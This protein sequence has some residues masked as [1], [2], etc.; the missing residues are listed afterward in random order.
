MNALR[1]TDGS[2][3]ENQYPANYM[4]L[5]M[6]AGYHWLRGE[7][8]QYV[9]VPNVVD[10]GG[11]TYSNFFGY[12]EASDGDFGW[13]TGY[14]RWT[15]AI[16]NRMHAPTSTP[17]TLESEEGR[18]AAKAWLYNHAGDND[19][20]AGGLIAIDVAC[21]TNTRRP[22]P[23][24]PANDAA[25]VTGMEYMHWAPTWATTRSPSWD[26]TTA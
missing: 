7:I 4:W 24:T 26:M 20:K 12:Q 25:Q 23:K 15:R 3:A 14:D 5:L 10:Y 8:M 21:G 1:D 22:I 9:G 6:S 2:L 19:Y 17:M 13:M 16:N 18:M 11:R